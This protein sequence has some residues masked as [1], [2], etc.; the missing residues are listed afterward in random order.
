MKTIAVEKGAVIRRD[1]HDITNHYIVEESQ[2]VDALRVGPHR[3]GGR[4]KFRKKPVVVEAYQWTGTSLLDLKNFREA[5]NLPH[6]PIA[7]RNGMTGICI[8]TLE[9]DHIARKGDWIIKGVAGEY[10]PCKP[11]IFEATYDPL[12]ATDD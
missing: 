1:R 2:G 5:H 6:W 10:Y 12:E 8:P 9:G 3:K 11:D 4:M 7:S